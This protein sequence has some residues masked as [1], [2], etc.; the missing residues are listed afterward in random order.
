MSSNLATPTIF[1]RSLVGFVSLLAH[2]CWRNDMSCDVLQLLHV[3]V[4]DQTGAKAFE[5]V[6]PG[7]R[8]FERDRMKVEQAV[9]HV[10]KTPN[11]CNQSVFFVPPSSMSRSSRE[12]RSAVSSVT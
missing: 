7:A 8:D 6:H 10:H 1:I 3:C 4:P 11:E 5:P 9:V 12:T 2:H